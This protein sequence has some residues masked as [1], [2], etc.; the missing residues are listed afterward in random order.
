[1]KVHRWENLMSTINVQCFA[2]IRCHGNQI[3]EEYFFLHLIFVQ[4][5]SKCQVNC[6]YGSDDTFSRGGILLATIWHQ[7]E[8]NCIFL[9]KVIRKMLK[10]VRAKFSPNQQNGRHIGIFGGHI[11]ILKTQNWDFLICKCWFES[12]FDFTSQKT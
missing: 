5:Q 8:G 10:K 4:I 9:C 1:M 2:P 3:N 7:D 11:G 6:N 12:L